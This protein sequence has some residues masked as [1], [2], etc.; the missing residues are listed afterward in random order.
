[1]QESS[2]AEGLEQQAFSPQKTGGAASGLHFR[3]HSPQNDT[4]ALAA[5]IG[6]LSEG[7][8][9]ALLAALGVE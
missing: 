1:M 5:A 3:L 6:Q 9:T 2:G 7:E 8:R 4:A